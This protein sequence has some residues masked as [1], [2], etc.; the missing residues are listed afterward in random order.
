MTKRD[1]GRVLKTTA[2]SL[3][4][5]EHILELEGASLADLAEASG[6]AKSTVH[7][8]LNTLAEYGYVVS[9][10]NRYHLGAKFCHLGDYVRT[11]K[12]YRRIAEEAIAHLSQESALEADFA[13]EEGGRIV[14]LYGDLDFTNFPQFLVDGSPFHIH[15][16]ASGKAIVAE[17]PRER[18]QEIVDRWGLPATTERS[19][20]TEEKLFD[21]LQQVREQG[22]A[23][24]DGE[25]IEGLWAVG[26]AVKSP[27]GEV[28][29][30]LNLSGPAYAID[31]ETK[32]AQVELLTKAVET[33]ER[34]VTEM[35]GAPS[36]GGER[37]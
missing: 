14:S 27:R 4:L 32:A 3:Q 33:F 37:I 29:G 11:R 12:E 22:Y 28:Y 25:A 7:S 16:T 20:S 18:V 15:T 1:T 9:E 26:K 6:L 30:S 13:V 21:E 36:G 5:V 34:E 17:Y 10:D 24:S 2:L 31:D 23:E 19:I 8:H 35:Y